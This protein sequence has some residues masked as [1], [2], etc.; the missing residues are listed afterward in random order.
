MN[1]LVEKCARA[2]C[3]AGGFNPDDIMPNDGPRW[4]YYVEGVSAV[5]PVVLDHLREP[6][7]AMIDAFVSRALQ[8]SVSGEGGWSEYARNQW[9]TMIAAAIRAGTPG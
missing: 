6:T 9:Q 8:V 3:I 1:E 2:Q 7:P 5:I 4:L